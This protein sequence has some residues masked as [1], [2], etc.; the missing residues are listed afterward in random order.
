MRWNSSF[1]TFDARFSTSP[2]TAE[3][4]L[5]SFSPSAR[6]RRSPAS[7]SESVS[8]RMPPTMRSSVARSL[9]R[10]CAR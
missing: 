1:S 4:V 2:A 10:S 3:I 9:P 8:E 5:S 7:P 6:S